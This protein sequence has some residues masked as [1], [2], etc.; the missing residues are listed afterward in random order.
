MYTAK[1]AGWQN[2]EQVSDRLIYVKHHVV[3]WG[4]RRV[5]AV[6]R[7]FGHN[8]VLH[9]HTVQCAALLRAALQRTRTTQIQN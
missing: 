4:E 9:L 6:H 7:F 1:P 3:D 2:A 8:R 5:S